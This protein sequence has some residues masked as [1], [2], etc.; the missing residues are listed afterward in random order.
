MRTGPARCSKSTAFRLATPSLAERFATPFERGL[1]VFVKERKY[2]PGCVIE[3]ARTADELFSRLEQLL[4]PTAET[5]GARPFLFGKRPTLADAALY[6]QLAMLDL[7]AADRVSALCPELLAWKRRLEEKL[8]P[9]A[10]GRPARAHRARRPF[11]A[12]TR[13]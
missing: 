13:K 12:R 6:G 1:F 7:G 2:G 10:Y 3:W 11:K 8:G 9:P 5:L 4:A